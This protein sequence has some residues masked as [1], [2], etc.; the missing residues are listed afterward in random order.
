M[1]VVWWD[2]VPEAGAGLLP[3]QPVESPAERITEGGDKGDGLE[4]G[5]IPARSDLCPPFLGSV[6]PSGDGLPS[7]Q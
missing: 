5:P 1:L 3:L 2:S 4:S 6:P 7:G